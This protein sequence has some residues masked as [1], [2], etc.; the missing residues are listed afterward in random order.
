M[1]VRFVL[2]ALV[3]F[4][5]LPLSRFGKLVL[6]SS[7][8]WAVEGPCRAATAAAAAA[9]A[10]L[11]A[12]GGVGFGGSYASSR[13]TAVGLRFHGE[14][15]VGGSSSFPFA[16]FS[17]CVCLC[18]IWGCF[19]VWGCRS[20]RHCLFPTVYGVISLCIRCLFYRRRLLFLPRQ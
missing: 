11:L 7:L 6:G 2:S 18:A 4:W 13:G 10:A 12:A 19:G 17:R 16:C 5:A 20:G 9:S 3:I 8:H 14:F 15:T 1:W